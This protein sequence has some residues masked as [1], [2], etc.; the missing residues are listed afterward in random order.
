MSLEGKATAGYVIRG[1]I[2]S[3]DTVV[4]NAY[5]IAVQNGFEGT[6]AEWLASLKG[7]KGDRG[8]GFKVISYYPSLN[9]LRAAVPNPEPG[10]AYGVGTAPPYSIYV[11]ADGYGWVNNGPIQGVKGDPGEK[12]DPGDPG[13][14]GVYLG[15][16]APT[17][18]DVMV[19]IDPS[20][21]ADV[22]NAKG[23]SF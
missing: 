11:Y 7:D 10:D 20:G 19:W 4:L 1:R 14:S 15:A 8:G 21:E 17:D 18:P 2:A 23:V 9:A 6:E 16:K 3:A 5:A 22:V 13:K 12:G